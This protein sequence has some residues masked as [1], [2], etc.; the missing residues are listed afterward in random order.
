MPDTVHWWLLKVG[1]LLLLLAP[2][3]AGYQTVTSSLNMYIWFKYWAQTP[4]HPCQPLPILASL[5]TSSIIATS[6]YPYGSDAVKA[7][8]DGT[9]AVTGVPVGP[10]PTLGGSSFGR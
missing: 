8:V 2:N 5:I 1:E 3:V 4:K 9:F 7:R 10:E 6:A